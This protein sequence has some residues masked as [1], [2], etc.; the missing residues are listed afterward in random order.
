MAQR[1]TEIMAAARRLLARDARV[2]LS[3]RAVAAE[4]G[5]GAST[6]RHY[7]PTQADLHQALAVDVLG[8]T[9][10]DLRIA[11]PS[12]PS[13]ERLTECLAQ[14]LPARQ[15]D[16]GHLRVWLTSYAA[17]V[18]GEANETVR[19]LLA[20]LGKAARSRVEQWLGVVAAEGGLRDGDVVRARRLLL[21]MID[22]LALA[23]LAPEGDLDVAG[24]RAL[25]R[26]V[27]EDMT[28]D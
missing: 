10:E 6:L 7:F 8:T 3:V 11:D 28:V 19:G 4:A 21:A 12:V 25:L 26:G 2:A 14:F 16:V 20:G 13:A 23:L 18:G 5:I 22:G 27:V 15:E 1:R 24:A 9:I 17:A